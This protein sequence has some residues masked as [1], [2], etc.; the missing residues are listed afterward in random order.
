MR[1]LTVAALLL[2]VLLSSSILS[3]S[4]S[5]PAEAEATSVYIN[6]DGSVT[7]TGNVQRLGDLYTFVGDFAGPLYVQKDN[8]V[9]DGAGH[10]VTGASGRSIVLEGRHGVTLRNARVTLDGGY[11]IDVEDASDC[12]LMANTLVGTPQPIPGLPSDR[13]IGPYGINFLHSQNITVKDNV[14]TNFFVGLSLEWS[15]G[16]T[17]TG[18]TLQD[19][20]EGIDIVDST[21]CVFQNNRMVNSTF[22]IRAY[23]TYQYENDLDTSNT[24]DDKPIYYWVNA[25]DRAVPSDAAYVVLVKCTNIRLESASPRGVTVIST[26]NSVISG[27]S[28]V[29]SGDGIDLLNS[30]GIQIV[31]S[32]LR[33]SA[34]GVNLQNSSNNTISGNDVSG[35][36]TRGLNLGTGGNNVISNNTFA[37]DSYAIAPFQDSASNDNIISYNRFTNDTY[38]LTVQG[39]MTIQGNIF[40]NNE[41]GILLTSSSGC[42][43]TQN[44]FTN[45]KNALYI[46]SSSGNLIY[47][48]NFENNTNQVADAGASATSTQQ[49]KAS[50]NSAGSVQLAAFHASDVNFLPPPPSSNLWDNGS[51]G[52]HWSDYHGS[53]ANGDGVG[54]V[55]YSL[56][57]SNR[58]NY[59]LMNPVTVSEVPS[60][61]VNPPPENTTQSG[62]P[63][64]PQ[65]TVPEVTFEFIFAAVLAVAGGLAA[66]A[67]LFLK[68]RRVMP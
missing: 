55:A 24:I 7:G 21:G 22:S 67:G 18:N 53:D 33:G 20:I 48:N 12:V 46:S 49:A 32:V 62:D 47:L 6:G 60:V 23:L 35:A 68:R 42:T 36:M 38:A 29:G 10:T 37:S 40:E 59:P 14:L 39:S 19:G 13:L 57:G 63:Q 4:L 11:V 54:D 61:P 17:I 27:V 50:A 15:N 9:I 44:T 5:R 2:C 1:R 34:I 51:R 25:R 31:N 30:S 56:Y 43:I 65:G 26:T 66:C 16:H 52:N 45:N 41:I 58:D 3:C 28:L 64:D 8:V